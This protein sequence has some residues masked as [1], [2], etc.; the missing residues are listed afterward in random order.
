MKLTERYGGG[1]SEKTLRHCLR[2]AETFSEEDIISATQRQLTWAQYYTKLPDKKLLSEKLRK[3]IAIAR[4]HYYELSKS[5][6]DEESEDEK[7]EPT[8]PKN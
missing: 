6:K 8:E 1:W 7:Y 4:E 2:S 5:N 3:A